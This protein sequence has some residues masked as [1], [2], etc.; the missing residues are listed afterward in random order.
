MPH[1]FT[2]CCLLCNQIYHLYQNKS[3][4]MSSRIHGYFKWRKFKFACWFKSYLMN[5]RWYFRFKK[6]KKRMEKLG[7]VLRLFVGMKCT[8]YKQI[9][10][11][12]LAE[13]SPG[14]HS[15]YY[16]EAHFMSSLYLFD[17]MKL[18]LFCY[19][20]NMFFWLRQFIQRHSPLWKAS[21]NG[22]LK[23]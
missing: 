11:K 5:R 4:A 19:A 3:F 21:T 17:R 13:N 16:K 20:K 8:L 1:S 10:N 7:M 6:K 22:N 2:C 14:V 12:N 9:E 15:F 18:S 23:L